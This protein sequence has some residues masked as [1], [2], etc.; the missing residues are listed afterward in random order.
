MYISFIHLGKA[1]G[2]IPASI[3][4]SKIIN[5]WSAHQIKDNIY[6]IEH[7]ALKGIVNT[8]FFCQKIESKE[9]AKWVW[10]N[11]VLK[12]GGAYYHCHFR[13][14]EDAFDIPAIE[15]RNVTGKN[16]K[17]LGILLGNKIKVIRQQLDKLK[18]YSSSFSHV[19][20]D[21]ELVKTIRT[22]E[23]EKQAWFQRLN[24]DPGSCLLIDQERFSVIVLSQ[25][26]LVVEFP[27]D[28]QKG[29]GKTIRDACDY[30]NGHALV[31]LRPLD[32]VTWRR[33][34]RA[35]RLIQSAKKQGIFIP[36]VMSNIEMTKEF[37]LQRKCQSDLLSTIH[38]FGPEKKMAIAVRLAQTVNSLHQIGIVH[39]DL[40]LE[41]V[42]YHDGEIY[43]TDFGFSRL[44][45][46]KPIKGCYGTRGM[47]APE[48]IN[49]GIAYEDKKIL[50]PPRDFRKFDSFSFG[51]M[52]W[53]MNHLYASPFDNTCIQLDLNKID[54][55]LDYHEQLSK[56]EKGTIARVMRGLMR[57]DPDRRW[58][59]EKA[60]KKLN[61]IWES[62]DPLR[63]FAFCDYFLLNEMNI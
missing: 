47:I 55:K 63:G 45:H 35:Y 52:L 12:V 48:L 16:I 37:A 57:K 24:K 3:S 6:Y 59:M 8:R 11:V 46:T 53:S 32:K 10:P 9:K 62:K 25:N 33:E 58:N 40:K 43:L 28:I 13:A 31:C 34:M 15:I 30:Y 7:D 5:T 54:A 20:P 19:A 2:M 21:N 42:L 14:I 60:V 56:P 4:S 17:Q 22:I 27:N 51:V 49:E 61:Q 29:T 18:Q 41:N 23:K 1:E 50:G 39:C 44:A 38:D 36:G 26:H